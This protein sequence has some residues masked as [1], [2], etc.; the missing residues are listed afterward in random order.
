MKKALIT[1]ITGMV[2]S[3][4]ADHLLSKTSWKIFGACR[5]RSPVENINH[6]NN[7]INHKDRVELDY[8]DLADYTSIYESLKRIKPDYIFH[9][10]AQSF[11]KASFH[12]RE[13]TYNTNILGTERLLYAVTQLKIKPIIHVCS[14][15]E[16]FGR[17]SKKDLPISEKNSFHPASPY[18]ISKIGT[19]Y[20]AR[21]YNE[22]FGLKTLITRMF[23]HTGPRRGDYFAE[24]S[25]AKQIASIELGYQK[26][27]I[28]VGNLKSLRTIADV[29][30]AVRAYHLL[31]TKKPQYGEVYNIGGNFSCTVG[32]ILKYLLKISKIKNTKIKIDKNRLRPIDADLQLPDTRK[33]KKHTGWKPQIKF[34]QT[35]QDLL[36]YWRHKLKNGP[37]INR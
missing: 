26:N 5:W 3:H 15:S 37:F 35:M 9:L 18:A 14:S 33:F 17:V 20:I 8:L 2:G 6:L 4:L 34:K 30:D 27:I 22:A 10:A 23:T 11:P 7:R 36:D 25:F 12:M 1:G 31:V 29:R 28:S 32:E 24:S 21:Y 13:T 16:V 19:D